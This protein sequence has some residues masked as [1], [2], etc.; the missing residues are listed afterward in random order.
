MPYGELDS[1]S[2][3]FAFSFVERRRLVVGFGKKK[4]N[5]F[6]RIPQMYSVFL[7]FP[8]KNAVFVSCYTFLFRKRRKRKKKEKVLRAN[9]LTDLCPKKGIFALLLYIRFSF[10]PSSAATALDFWLLPSSPLSST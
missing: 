3:L 8:L 1:E 2:F 7:F 10:Y 6:S 5:F 9:V 4:I